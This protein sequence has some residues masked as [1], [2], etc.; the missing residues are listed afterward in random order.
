MESIATERVALLFKFSHWYP[1]LKYYG[2]YEK[3]AQ[4]MN[5]LWK[6]TRKLWAAN[7]DAFSVALE[8]M[9][10]ILTYS[11]PF[12]AEISLFLLENLR[13]KRY[14]LSLT[15][16]SDFTL[17]TEFLNS[18]PNLN[19][20]QLK[21]LWCSLTE[22]N[23]EAYNDLCRFIIAKNHPNLTLEVLRV[24]LCSPTLWPSSYVYL[25]K[26]DVTPESAKK[27]PERIH[28]LALYY[29]TQAE[30]EVIKTLTTSAEKILIFQSSI[31]QLNNLDFINATLKTTLRIL[32]IRIQKYKN[33][34]FF[35]W[36]V[37]WFKKNVKNYKKLVLSSY[38]VN[39]S[40]IGMY[41]DKYQ[42]I[43]IKF[44]KQ[45]EDIST[46][47]KYYPRIYYFGKQF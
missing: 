43:D 47:V 15:C 18:V 24:T 13:F 41:F 29:Q 46:I 26:I 28:M 5:G 31:K 21:D 40:A 27:M 1:V 33:P 17:I 4:M 8:Y 22:H 36:I 39:F 12:D 34:L 32:E 11:E 25:D 45:S 6:R 16:D 9:R 19:F 30:V 35:D 38:E 14:S 44:G 42:N 23:Y 2:S 20:L 3:A 10:K 7:C 37:E